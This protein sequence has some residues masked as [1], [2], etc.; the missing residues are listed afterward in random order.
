[1]TGCTRVASAIAGPAPWLP[2]PFNHPGM[3]NF[4]ESGFVGLRAAFSGRIAAAVCGALEARCG[5]DLAG[6]STCG[7]NRLWLQ[8]TLRATPFVDALRA[9]F[10]SAVD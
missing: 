1:M 7:T 8:E 6:P 9:L 4:V 5:V 2:G 3:A 10:H